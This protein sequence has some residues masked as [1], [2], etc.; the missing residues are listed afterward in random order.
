M[1]ALARNR[2]F[3]LPQVIWLFAYF[4]VA[5]LISTAC[6]QLRDEAS[7]MQPCLNEDR[8]GEKRLFQSGVFSLGSNHTYTEEAPERQADVSSF[9]I[10]IHE[11]T[12]SQF[13][14]F[15]EET[16][17]QTQAER[18]FDKSDFPDIAEEF[19]VPG[20]MVFTP[21]DSM[22]GSSPLSWWRFI[23]GANWR[24]PYGPD[25]SIVG[26]D[27]HPVV[28]VTIGDARAYAKWAGR[29]LPTEAEWEYAATYGADQ[30][31]GTDA[32]SDHPDANYWQG[33]FPVLNTL[34]DGYRFSAPVG[35]FGQNNAGLFDMV[36]NVWE[37]TESIYYPTHKEDVRQAMP[38][39][40]YDPSQPGI[41]VNVIK[42]G[43]YLCARNYCLRYRPEARQGQDNFLASSH[44]GFR[45]VNAVSSN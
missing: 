15:V 23:S 30:E 31:S 20:S 5:L 24:H 29:R 19:R 21:P 39:T 26:K 12:N 4:G 41:A 36:G 35:C 43:S 13:A 32:S 11:V 8:I 44:I 10:D 42:G 18:G 14:A 1:W 2:C 16:N 28:H 34:D 38:D 40:G 22:Q 3:R 25:S 17:Y 45:T 7:A 33:I 6:S 37:L 27:F 9:Q